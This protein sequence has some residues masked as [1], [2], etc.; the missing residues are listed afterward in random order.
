M[1]WEQQHKRFYKYRIYKVLDNFLDDDNR[2]TDGRFKRASRSI[3]YDMQ[4]NKDYNMSDENIISNYLIYTESW[5]HCYCWD[6]DLKDLGDSYF[7][8]KITMDEKEQ[9]QQMDDYY[10]YKN[11]DKDNPFRRQEQLHEKKSREERERYEK[12]YI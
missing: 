11:V 4:Y 5:E 8:I 3:Y 2:D 6:S 12:K 1:K 7:M 9:K 10:K